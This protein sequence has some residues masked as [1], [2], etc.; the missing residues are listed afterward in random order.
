MSAQGPFR[1]RFWLESALALISAVCLVATL[2]RPDWIELIIGL[3]PDASGGGLELGVSLGLGIIALASAVAASV[4]FR[5]A[6]RKIAASLATD[7]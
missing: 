5:S 4:D 3:D 7:H 2:L 1:S 6:R